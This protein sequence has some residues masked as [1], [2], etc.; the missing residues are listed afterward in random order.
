MKASKSYEGMYALHEDF[1]HV[2]TLEVKSDVRLNP[3]LSMLFFYLLSK[4]GVVKN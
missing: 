1:I 2:T 3:V 4:R